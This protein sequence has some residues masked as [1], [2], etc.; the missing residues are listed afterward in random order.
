MRN[1]RLIRLHSRR[2][3]PKKKPERN[4]AEKLAGAIMET[5]AYDN[6]MNHTKSLL[7]AMR[8]G[9]AIIFT[10]SVL[11]MLRSMGDNKVVFNIETRKG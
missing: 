6:P 10:Q 1:A 9:S 2:P 8:D 5:Y 3:K 4:Q 11:S 7:F